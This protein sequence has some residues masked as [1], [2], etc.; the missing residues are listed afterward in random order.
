MKRPKFSITKSVST[1]R[2]FNFLPTQQIKDLKQVK[3]K[4]RTSSKLNWAINAYKEWRQVRLDH[5]YNESIFNSDIGNLNGLDEKSFGEALC[6]FIPE[7]TKA[8][9][10]GLYPAKTL[11]QLV[12]ALQKYLNVNKIPWKLIDGPNFENVRVV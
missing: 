1:V 3:L 12:V 7:V 2:K 9:G 6:Y 10:E 8:K 11:Y 5:S 4:E